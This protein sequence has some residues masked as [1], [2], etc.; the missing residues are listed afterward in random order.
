MPVSKPCITDDKILLFIRR[1]FSQISSFFGAIGIGRIPV[2][3]AN[4]ISEMIQHVSGRV[5]RLDPVTVDGD[6]LGTRIVPRVEVVAVDVSVVVV[7]VV[8][9]SEENA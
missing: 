9:G 1:R 6:G 4:P 8:A 7:V 3:G 2:G 5:L